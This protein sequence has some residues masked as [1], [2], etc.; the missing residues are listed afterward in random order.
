[1]I[2]PFKILK[3]PEKTNNSSKQNTCNLP[4]H[5][6]IPSQN[7]FTRF[8]DFCQTHPYNFSHFHTYIHTHTHTYTHRN[9]SSSNESTSTFHLQDFRYTP[10]STSPSTDFPSLFTQ[11]FRTISTFFYIVHSL[12]PSFS[13][14]HRFPIIDQFGQ[15][16]EETTQAN[17]TLITYSI[18]SARIKADLRV[19]N[20]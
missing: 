13:Q 19:E 15:L 2:L 5:Y 14:Y 11:L 10:P 6:Y 20:R 9:I 16:G 17:G 4:F 1:M 8:Y 18:S 3:S 12:C 7:S